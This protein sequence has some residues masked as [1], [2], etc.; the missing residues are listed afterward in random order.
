[1]PDGLVGQRASHGGFVRDADCFDN[2]AFG[3]SPA[4]A[5]AMDPQQRLLLEHGYEALHASGQ[6]REAL[7]GSLTGVFVGIAFCDW[8]TPSRAARR[9][10]R[11][12]SPDFGRL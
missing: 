1:M 10:P 12:V 6:G 4:E 9:L 2:A 7:A 5:A 8:H 3:V 11:L